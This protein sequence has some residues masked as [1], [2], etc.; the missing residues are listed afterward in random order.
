MTS[1][2]FRMVRHWVT[3]HGK[4]CADLFYLYIRNHWASSQSGGLET[5][6]RVNKEG[7]KATWGWQIIK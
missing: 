1:L 7:I 6:Q 4:S 3:H 2:D 5:E